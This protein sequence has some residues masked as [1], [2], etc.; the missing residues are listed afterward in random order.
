MGFAQVL[1]EVIEGTFS[2]GEVETFSV[3]RECETQKLGL[4]HV[5]VLHAVVFLALELEPKGS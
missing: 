4:V 1:F 3:P 2:R 5:E